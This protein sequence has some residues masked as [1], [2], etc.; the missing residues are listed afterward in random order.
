VAA[1]M[2]DLVH[3]KQVNGRYGHVAGDEALREGD[4]ADDSFDPPA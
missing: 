2:V 4:E 3:F 1:L